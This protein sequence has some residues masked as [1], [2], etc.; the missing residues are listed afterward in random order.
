ML[1]IIELEI[2]R[3]LIKEIQRLNSHANMYTQFMKN[4][5]VIFSEN[6]HVQENSAR[7]TDSEVERLMMLN[8]R[9]GEIE[10]LIH[11]TS[12]ELW[13][14]SI[15]KIEN[16]NNLMGDFEIDTK[17]DFILRDDDPEASEDSDNILTTREVFVYYPDKEAVGK[18]IVDFR[19]SCNGD[20]DQLA[21]EPHCYLF[22]DLY[23]HSYGVEQ[24]SVPLRDCLRIG[25]LWI[26]VI[27]RQQYFFDLDTGR[28]DKSIGDRKLAINNGN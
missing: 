24:P 22:H 2:L 18:E 10:T 23:D 1:S 19:E 7:F 9:L 11:D 17:I 25:S 4:I 6:R 28:W 3:D 21:A 8:R 27:V 14:E 16:Q 26:D 20:T 13:S 12:H 15:G 5:N